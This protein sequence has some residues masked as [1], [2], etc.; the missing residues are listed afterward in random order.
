MKR[1]WEMAVAL[2]LVTVQLPTATQPEFLPSTSCAALQ[3][4]LFPAKL[5]VNVIARFTVKMLPEPDTD[6]TPVF[7]LHWLFCRVPALPIAIPVP[8]DDPA[9]F[10]R[11]TRL[12]RRSNQTSQEL[13]VTPGV[14]ITSV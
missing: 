6:D 3:M 12:A 13:L 1:T 10:I 5:D 11:Y 2:V 4:V 14:N 9:S 7:T 8:K